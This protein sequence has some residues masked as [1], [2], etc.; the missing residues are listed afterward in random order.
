MAE[1]R[2]AFPLSFAQQRLWFLDQLVP[3]TALYNLT[4]ALSVRG[5]PDIPALARSINEVVTRHESLRTTFTTAGDAPMQLVAGRCELPMPVTD[6]RHLPPTEREEAAERLAN[7]DASAP[8]N[9][10]IG[11]LLRVQLVRVNDEESILLATMHHIVTDGWSLGVF[12]RELV[13]LYAAFREGRPSPL[14]P[15][16]IQYADYAVWQRERLQGRWLDRLLSYWTEQLAD[17]PKLHVPTDRL[18]PAVSTYAGALRTASFPAETWTSLKALSRRE[19]VTPF[20]V[21][22]A[23]FQVLLARYSGQDDVAVGTP[24]AGRDRTEI[25]GLIGFFVNTLVIRTNLEGNPPFRELLRRVSQVT[26]D[27]YAHQELPFEQL[28]EKLR[29]ARDLGRNPLFDVMFQL[30]NVPSVGRREAAGRRMPPLRIDRGMANFDLALDLREGGERLEAY[31]EYSTELFDDATIARLLDHY[32]ILLAG[33]AEN[34]DRPIGDLPLL[35]ASEREQ[36]VVR[37]NPTPGPSVPRY[38]HRLFEQQVDRDPSAVAVDG[39]SQSLTYGELDARANR[40]A[41]RLR[42]LGVGPGARVAM[43]AT[44][45]EDAIVGLLAVLKSGG[46]WALIDPTYPRARRELLIN[47][48]APSVMLCARTLMEGLQFERLPVIALDDSEA[49]FEFDERLEPSGHDDPAY[50]IYTSGSTGEPK[51]VEVGHSALANHAT[52]IMTLLG[53]RPGDR[54]LQFSSLSFDVALEEILPTLAAGGTVVV[55]ERAAAPT[56]DELLD[57][58]RV[59]Q[60]TVL[61]LPA[62]YWHQC[63]ET[64][65]ASEASVPSSLRLVVTGSERVQ[66]ARVAAWVARFGDRLPLINAYGLTETT[67]T[68]MTHRVS[69]SDGVQGSQSEVP[70][71][72]PIANTQAYV[73]DR[74]GQLAPIGVPGELMIGGAALA[75]G[76]LNRPE[77]SAR[78]FRSHPYDDRPG[79]RLFR[80]GDRARVLPSGDF[81]VLGR[82]DDQVKVRGMRVEPVEVERALCAHPAVSDAGVVAREDASDDRRLVAYVVPRHRHTSLGVTSGDVNAQGQHEQLARWRDSYDELYAQPNPQ[83]DPTFNIVGWDSSYDSRPISVTAMREQVSQT[84]DR[85][86]SLR[87]ARVLEI[88]CGTGLVLFQVAPHCEQYIGVD[89]S[90][91]AIDYV[92]ETLPAALRPKVRLERSNA[93][94]V[95]QIV[96]EPVDL[97]VLN[98]VVQ[99]FPDVEYLVRVLERAW[100][101]LRP[102]G[103]VFVGDVRNLRLL[104][105]FHASVELQ[106][107]SANVAR[108]ALA[109]RVRQRA[110]EEQEL[111][112]D[113]AFFTAL[114]RELPR[115]VSLEVMLKRGREAN[116]L[117]QFRYDVVM[118][119]GRRAGP[120]SAVTPIDFSDVPSPLEQLR[121]TIERSRPAAIDIRNLPNRRVAAAVRAWQLISDAKGAATAGDVRRHL[122]EA[123]AAGLDPE[124]VWELARGFGYVARV[125]WSDKRAD[126]FDVLLL[127]DAHEPFHLTA[128]PTRDVGSPAASFGRHSATAARWQE[129]ANDPP[130]GVFARRLTA[131]LRTWLK[132]RLPEQ[133][134]PAAFVTLDA[135]PRTPGGKLDQRA[136]PPLDTERPRV[137][138]EY[139]AP[140]DDRERTLAGIWCELLGVKRVGVHDNFFELGGDSILSIQVITRA[141]R[142]GLRLTARHLFQHQTIAGLAAVADTQTA[143]S[144]HARAREGPVPLIPIQRW[145][146]EQQFADPSH[147]N[148]ALLI[149]L[150]SADAPVIERAVRHVFPRHQALHLRF[151]QASDSWQ[152]RAALS[153]DER[154]FTRI[155]LPAMADSDVPEAIERVAAEVQTSLDLARGPLAR[156]VLFDLGAHRAARLLLV[157]HHLVVD[158]VSWRILLDDL[159]SACTQLRDNRDIEPLPDTTPWTNWVTLLEDVASSSSVQQEVAYWVRDGRAPVRLPVDLPGGANDEASGRRVRATLDEQDTRA[160]LQEVPKAY[161]TQI[162]EVLLAALGWSFAQWTG[163]PAI[164]VDLEGHGRDPLSDDIDLSRTVGWFTTVFPVCIDVGGANTPSE[165]LPR[166]KEELRRLPRK[167]IG[168]GL[169]RYLSGLEQARQLRALPHAEVNFN[170]L[171][172]FDSSFSPSSGWRLAPEPVGETRSPRQRRPYLLEV[173]A[174]VVEGRLDVSWTY[175]ASMHHRSTVSSLAHAFTEALREIVGHCRGR[176]TSYTPSDFPLAGLDQHQLDRLVQKL[177]RGGKGAAS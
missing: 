20:M 171:G 78:R 47:D 111:L 96:S 129:Y 165:A 35:T 155:D 67:I 42:E 3:N 18:R 39:D 167:G 119:N 49:L 50:V 65:T 29:P 100:Q 116:E 174:A 148:Q 141:N 11:P 14:S 117:T 136:L 139:T 9:L 125:S 134:V 82:F 102:G 75:R 110:R 81:E 88:G 175:G 71:G 40:L 16:P 22:L 72:R 93:D 106:R 60:L 23:A 48:L 36:I 12:R 7:A 44:Q 53:L 37:W 130:Q 101:L 52:A 87:P 62:T 168:Y 160:L 166:I 46:A 161:R 15:P 123:S 95:D 142:A 177:S 176:A 172:Q 74:F 97:V 105:M 32:G 151:E 126:A 140:R 5:E 157:A 28:V 170:Y 1:Q 58:S 38:V 21:L 128:A 26:L 84:A 113:P 4:L 43:Y 41:S 138:T 30:Q 162:N 34:P 137:D 92:R 13:E 10:A 51:G 31:L 2:F 107:C 19:G 150:P 66:P 146:F 79:A 76:Y 144:V 163:C 131:Q 147:Y 133:M 70:I 57:R 114:A 164:L 55:R 169:L 27:A 54:V 83:P 17:L 73:F 98:S 33:I 8:F 91:A 132:E 69:S 59:D 85:I 104:E 118:H 109:A 56:P 120:A 124:E 154:V 143:P 99:Y 24:I 25:E 173:N 90:S 145:F 122:D 112:I 77:L 86:L 156:A 63:V 6:L 153:E 135:L 64:F 108:T 159:Q 152:Q 68:C 103:A 45:S 61:N 115:A 94:G 89:F 80:T 158:G 127:R 149:E 121:V